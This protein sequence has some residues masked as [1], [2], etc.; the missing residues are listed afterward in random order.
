MAMSVRHQNDVYLLREIKEHL[1]VLCRGLQHR[2]L[3]VCLQF[4]HYSR[5]NTPCR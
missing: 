2:P 1:E 4:L 5:S 3:E